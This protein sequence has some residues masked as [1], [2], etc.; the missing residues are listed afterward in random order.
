MKKLSKYLLSAGIAVAVAVATPGI[1]LAATN[2]SSSVID[3]TNPS[4][5][6]T[7]SQDISNKKFNTNKPTFSGRT[8]PNCLVKILIY[9]KPIVG[10]TYSDSTG[11]WSWTPSE[12]IPPGEHIIQATAT[13]AQGHVSLA[14]APVKFSIASDVAGATSKAQTNWVIYAIWAL[15][16]IFILAGGYALTRKKTTEE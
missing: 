12:P 11:Y 9:S 13:D 4:H 5:A 10:T 8:F 15:V 16:A 14:S 6:P 3:P 7:I 1:G 2:S